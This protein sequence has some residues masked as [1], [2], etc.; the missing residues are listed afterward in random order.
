MCTVGRG[1]SACLCALFYKCIL[2]GFVYF[3]GFCDNLWQTDA[4]LIA[5]KVTVPSQKRLLLIFYSNSDCSRKYAI[6]QL[7]LC[8]LFPKLPAFCVVCDEPF[9]TK[10]LNFYLGANR[11]QGY[12]RLALKVTGPNYSFTSFRGM[13]YRWTNGLPSVCALFTNSSL[14]QEI[15]RSST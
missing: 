3:F 9:L 2:S 10:P 6:S 8:L 12:V 7:R 14:Q 4:Q 1:R 5:V 13:K 15:S 11:R